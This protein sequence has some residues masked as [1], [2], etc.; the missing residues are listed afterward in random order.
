MLTFLTV[1]GIG[2]VFVLTYIGASIV[3]SQEGN[4][5]VAGPPKHLSPKK[6][7]IAQADEMCARASKAGIGVPPPASVAEMRAFVSK[8]ID[9]EEGLQRRMKAL[10]APAKSK[11]LLE[12]FERVRDKE[13]RG[14]RGLLALLQDG[15]QAAAIS[16][17]K[18]VAATDRHL[19]ALGRRYGFKECGR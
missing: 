11:G 17:L 7:F 19:G 14:L 9:N 18:D 10:R 8:S 2:V 12:R 3:F 13:L 16:A 5:E 4:A 6:S 15:D 1:L